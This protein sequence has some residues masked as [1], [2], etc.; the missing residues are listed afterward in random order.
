VRAIAPRSACNVVHAHVGARG[1][2][3]AFDV[4]VSRA[5][6]PVVKFGLILAVMLMSA[7]RVR[8]IDLPSCSQEITRCLTVCRAVCSRQLAEESRDAHMAK[9]LQGSVSGGSVARN[10]FK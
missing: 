7:A 3:L 5:A 2:R 10:S 6:S 1:I 4:S 9:A 8:G